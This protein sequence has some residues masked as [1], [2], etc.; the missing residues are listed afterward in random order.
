MNIDTELSEWLTQRDGAGLRRVLT[1]VEA[2]RGMEYRVN[3][4][5]YVSFCSNDYLGL[6]DDDCTRQGARDALEQWGCGAGASR[7]VSGDLGIIR[8][9]ETELAAW[10]QTEAALVYPSGYMANIG[11]ISALAGPGD[12]VFIDR[13]AHASLVDGTRLSRA[14]LRVFPHND[15][16]RL[17]TLLGNVSARRTIVIT[18]SVFSMDGDT[19]PLRA[20]SMVC[21]KHG[22][23]LMVDEAHALGVYGGGR[24][25]VNAE[26]LS[27]KIDV[28]VGTLSKAI[29]SQGG[30]AAGSRKLCD[31][32][33]NTSRSFIYTTGINPAAAGAA[34]A[35]LRCL[36]NDS[37][38]IDKL[39]YNISRF[40]SQ[41][42][43]L[44]IMGQGPICPVM[45][46]TA[47]A[48]CTR[49]RLLAEEGYLA[50]AIR[51]PTVPE[52]GARMRVTLSAL[53][54][55]EQIDRFARV[56]IDTAN[57]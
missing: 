36:K 7:L 43:D 41:V 48:A 11:V 18:E 33:V 50:P 13:L 54:S 14:R 46:G 6:A 47:Q 23:L 8:E 20:L 4:R 21:K 32:L 53:H 30:F 35:A 55:P 27:G 24:G 3:G 45:T 9:L 19:A 26:G 25:L 57:R 40:R 15:F 44:R 39:W 38:R 56:L 17:D 2:R 28:L 51:P 10:K 37:T 49:A 52:G 31:Y 1:T 29:G 16:E 34:I 5:W 42:S 12:T 22:A